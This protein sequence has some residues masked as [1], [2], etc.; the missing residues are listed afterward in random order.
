MIDRDARAGA[1][2]NVKPTPRVVD[3]DGHRRDS[4]PIKFP[5]FSRRGRPPCPVGI[6]LRDR[7]DGRD[8]EGQG[9][10]TAFRF[11][12]DLLLVS[13]GRVCHRHRPVDRSM[14]S[15]LSSRDPGRAVI[16]LGISWQACHPASLA[17]LACA[18]S[19][20]HGRFLYSAHDRLLRRQRQELALVAG[21]AANRLLDF[22]NRDRSPDHPLCKGATP[23]DADE[24]ESPNVKS[25]QT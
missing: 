9:P 25:P 7:R 11:R 20:G 2:V 21:P 16:R 12:N 6:G 14:V 8:A 15:G 22:S 5:G 3:N 23:V 19:M 4:D 17:Q 13:V 18:A 1:E 24:T 10:G